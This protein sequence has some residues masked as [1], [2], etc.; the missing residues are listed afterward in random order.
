MV[1]K[2]K[3]NK[4]LDVLAHLRKTM[5]A[6]CCIGFVLPFW[7]LAQTESSVPLATFELSLQ[8]KGMLAFDLDVCQLQ[9]N[10]GTTALELQYALDLQQLVNENS[11]TDSVRFHVNIKFLDLQSQLIHASESLKSVAIDAAK[12]SRENL[13]FVDLKRFTING[14]T[15][16]LFVN[17]SDADNKKQGQIKTAIAVKPLPGNRLSIS[18]PVF[19]SHVQRASEPSAFVRQGFLMI[20]NPNRIYRTDGANTDLTIYQEINGLTYD[21]G[22]Q[23]IYSLNYTISDL[24][25]KEVQNLSHQTLP[26]TRSN[27]SRLDKISL[28]NLQTGVYRLKVQVIDIASNTGASLQKYFRVVTGQE[29]EGMLLPMAKSD[30]QKYAKQIQYLAS[31][32]EKELFHS[33]DSRGKQAFLLQFW[34]SR[35][36]TPETSENEFMMEYFKRIAYCDA[37]FTN[38]VSSD[39]GRIYL[40]YGEPM[41]IQR[42][43]ASTQYNKPV[44][45]WIYALEG[46]SEFVFVDRI[47]GD[48]FVLMHSS[49]PDEYHNPDWAETLQ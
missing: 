49:H 46:T 6:F 25:G 2:I 19:L 9:G 29:S 7:G 17:I 44:E 48:Q 36:T 5:L 1:A 22:K 35:D 11:K 8:S 28:A 14:D 12:D 40:K 39:Q 16:Q 34:R 32:E 41:E 13:T 10:D 33:L 47:G 20:P 24:T 43:K 26:V 18:D 15:L 3:I 31:S 4:H 42:L 21:T 30:V 37:H 38:G 27:I 45:I 23:S